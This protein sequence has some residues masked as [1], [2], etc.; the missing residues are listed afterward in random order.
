MKRINK[1]IKKNIKIKKRQDK[2]KK[3]GTGT[4]KTK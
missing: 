1:R 3:Q 4:K 2:G